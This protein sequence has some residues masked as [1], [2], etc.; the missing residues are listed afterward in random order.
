M[1]KPVMRKPDTIGSMSN[2]SEVSNSG[3]QNGLIQSMN[4]QP[5]FQNQDQGIIKQ[6]DQGI[7]R[8]QD[9][10]IIRQQ[11][12]NNEREVHNGERQPRETQEQNDYE[13]TSVIEYEGGGG[14]NIDKKTE[15]NLMR[16]LLDKTLTNA[17]NPPPPNPIETAVSTVMSQVTE[18]IAAKMLGN[19][20]GGVGAPVGKSNFLIELL[21]TQFGAQ[22]GSTLGNQIPA[23]ITTLTSSLGEQRTKQLVDN[24]NNRINGET[25]NNNS[26]TESEIANANSEKQ[27]DYVLALDSNNPA[28]LNQ[29]ANAMGLSVSRAKEI[30][31]AHQDDINRS[32]NAKLGSGSSGSS[33]NN[34]M[35]QALVM[36][37]NE[38]A[39]M[40]ATMNELQ[41]KMNQID[42]TKQIPKV[43]DENQKWTDDNI[44]A[45]LNQNP[46]GNAEVNLFSSAIKVDVD[47]IKGDNLKDSFFDEGAKKSDLLEQVIDDKGNS[48]FKETSQEAQSLHQTSQEL[49]QKSQENAQ[50]MSSENNKKKDNS[51]DEENK[52]SEAKSEI[53][54]ETKPKKV[55]K[56]KTM[57]DVAKETVLETEI[58]ST[59][60]T[61][62]DV[63]FYD[64]NNNLINTK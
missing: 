9:Q 52:N 3:V 11:N 62:K 13:E 35:T 53:K 54:I 20:G 32:R 6:Q 59:T 57:K 14:Y 49:S 26:L 43:N 18:G 46:G 38:I 22:I 33:N 41:G 45:S 36:L 12:Y 5:E 61:I 1:F 48:S 51:L 28:H 2:Q 63:D 56:L 19:I 64:I 58:K 55:F 4:R 60:E 39:S 24:V 31:I 40:K 37:V 16:Q 29:Y 34:E 21:N 50:D 23:I 25:G 7:I 8:Q 10:G 30:L 44:N 47:Q 15:K 42:T 17:L 27:K